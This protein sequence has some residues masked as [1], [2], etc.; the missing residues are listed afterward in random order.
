VEKFIVECLE[1]WVREMHVDGF[2]FDEGSILTRGEDG[3]PMMHPPVVWQIE[4]S[5]TLADTKIIAE[6]W[7][8]AGLYQVGY[9]P[10]YRWCEWNGR[11]RDDVRKFVKGEPGMVGSVASRISGSADLYQ[12]RGH[13]PINSVNFVTC[14]D[15]FTL[16][17]TVSYDGKHN[18]ANGENNQD[19][20]N[21]NY[22]WNCGWEG[23]TDDPGIERLRRRQIKNFATILLV[24]QGIPML[25][26]GDEVRRT[27]GGNNNA[28]CQDN[29]ISWLDWKQV[30]KEQEIFRFFQQMLAFR[31][32]HPV[33]QCRSFFVG[34]PNETGRAY[35]TW[36]GTKLNSPG[37]NDP[38]A[39]AFAFTVGGFVGHPHIHVM[40][41]MFWEP[42]EFELPAEQ[43]RGWFRVV[44]TALPSPQDIAAS[45]QE[46]AISTPTYR[47]EGR[48]CVVLI[49][50]GTTN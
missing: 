46:V 45:G 11:F 14:H 39:R 37:W 6:A 34:E 4:L 50:K 33:L 41:N 25:C 1:Y 43:S 5:E 31:Q 7:D 47:V 38:G 28:Y 36:H 10:G 9:F 20:V 2:R 19:G 22:S 49:C 13:L 29:E 3:A 48:S 12:A 32:Q 23:P 26:M 15:G 8:A 24:S 21:D 44:D 30:E 35:I 17:D 40:M 27:Q 16:N 42:L 18:E